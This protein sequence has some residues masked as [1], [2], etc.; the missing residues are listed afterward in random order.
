MAISWNGMG[1]VLS[2]A[3]VGLAGYAVW[4]MSDNARVAQA[5][6]GTE[7]ALEARL[8]AL[9]ASI[10]P[11]GGARAPALAPA[12]VTRRAGAPHA[13]TGTGDATPAS[14]GTATNGAPATLPDMAQRVAALE[15]QLKAALET[16]VAPAQQEISMPQ[17]A[18]LATAWYGSVDDVAKGL[19]LTAPQKADFERAV[20]GAKLEIDQLHKVPDESGKTWEQAMKDGVS[21][22]NGNISYDGAKIQAFREKVIP[23]RNE[24]FGAADR[25]LRAEAKQRMRES[26]SRDQQDKFDK[27]HVDGLLPGGDGGDG[28]FM[29]MF[30]SFSGAINVA[31]PVEVTAPSLPP[32]PAK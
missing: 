16:A 6:E 31:T 4:T 23:G 9:E 2:L 17:G 24:S 11:A 22:E 1:L 20:L 3:S 30:T 29:T 10:R 25:R 27:S 5:R 13:A 18:E 7:A 12:P 14:G 26:L 32:A 28:G 8:A 15:Q 21:V 19:A